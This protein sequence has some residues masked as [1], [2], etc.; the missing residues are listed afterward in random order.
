MS[1]RIKKL[2]GMQFFP[3]LHDP[4]GLKI[5]ANFAQLCGCAQ[6]WSVG[7]F[8][9]N[10]IE[11]IRAQLGGKHALIAI[12]G[13]V[14]SSV[15]AALMHAAIGTR[16]H[17][18]HVDTGLMRKDESAMIARVFGEMGL[19]LH[20][21]DAHERFLGRLRGVRDAQ[22]KRRII[23]EEFL[24]VFE[25]EARK[26]G[27]AEILV[28]GTIYT[29]VLGSAEV[30][31]SRNKGDM[32]LPMGFG[33]VIEPLRALFKDEVR[34]IGSALGLPEEM[35]HRQPFPGPGLAVRCIGEVT[36]E[37]LEILREADA[38]F[39]EEMEK[40]GLDR[41]IWQHFAVLSGGTMPGSS[42]IALRAVNSVDSAT[43]T[44]ARLPYDLLETCAE[45]ITAEIGRVERVVYDITG[46][47][48]ATIE[49]E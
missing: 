21:V 24:S 34:Q 19:N 2:Y 35:I 23:N 42:I 30:S 3:D 6:D 16:M 10:S 13:G 9:E 28:R 5:L 17:C 8:I 40:A 25:E 27:E 39:R 48:A 31:N 26:L 37:K 44:A 12:S 32:P 7:S 45:R 1:A 29:D 47:P 11:N 18:V 41:R 14:D 22:E 20:M 46:K 33:G 36:A 43:A 49:W 4:E 38:I 15:C